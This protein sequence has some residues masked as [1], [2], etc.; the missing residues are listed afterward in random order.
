MKLDLTYYKGDIPYNTGKNEKKII[1]YIKENTSD[2]YEKIIEKDSSDETILA[3]S[4]IRNNIVHVYDF[5]EN[6]KVLEIGAHLGEITNLLCEKT[7]RVVAIESVKERAEAIAKRCEKNQNLEILVG[8]IKDIEITEKFDYITLFGILEYAQLFFDTENPAIDLINYCKNLLNDE[9]KIL[10]AT[11]N[12]FALKSYVGELDECTNNEFDSITGYKSSSKTYKL[13]KKEIEKI[14][15]NVGLE[16]YKFLYPLPDYKL[17]SIIFSDKYLPTSSKINAYFPYY[18]DD[19]S[20]FFSEV[21]AYESIIKEDKEMFKFFANSYLIEVSK[22]EFEDDTRFVSFNNYRKKKYR[23]MTKI[24]TNVV[25]KKA[26]NKESIEHIENMKT[27]IQKIKEEGI[28]ILDEY[29]DDKIISK[30]VN[31]KLVSQK[32][33]DNLENK[34][35]I[36]DFLK[37]Y[38]DNLCK[39]SYEYKDDQVTVFNKYSLNVEKDV[40]KKF[41]FLKNGYWDMIFKNCFWIENNFVFFDQE[42]MEKDVPVEFLVYRCIVNIEK[43][44]DKIEEYKIYQELGIEEYIEL[45]KELDNK[46]SNEIFDNKIFELY[47]REHYNPIYD[48][49]KIKQELNDEISKTKELKKSIQNL[50]CEIFAKDSEIKNLKDELKGIYESKSWKLIKGINKFLNR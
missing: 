25:E 20:I 35:L 31:D 16:Y 38:K 45:F 10:I 49:G 24:R 40:L 9:G 43:L 3:L 42:W 44:R 5:K 11:N 1:N 21:D 27:N 2:E 32:I 12:K 26:I 23:L 15:K 28:N 6:S 47:I 46:I 17:P 34:E 50:S 4:T 13:G 37:K 19:S 39:L 8:N 29:K 18:R 33:G 22:N 14:L 41:K 48:N 30:F 36:L 7:S